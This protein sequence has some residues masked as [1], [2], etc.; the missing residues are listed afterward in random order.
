[1][2]YIHTK[3]LDDAFRPRLD[4]NP[5]Y[6]EGCFGDSSFAVYYSALEEDRCTK[7]I[8]YHLR[9]DEDLVE[10]PDPRYYQPMERSYSGS[11][12]M[13]SLL[14]KE[15]EHTDLTSSTSAG[16]PFCQ[17]LARDAVKR[18]YD[19]FLTA[20]ARNPEGT[21]VPV[22]TRT[23]LSEPQAGNEFLMTL[24]DGQAQFQAD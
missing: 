4:E 20:S 11:E 14:G 9:Q 18:G 17:S 13:V 21:C 5:P 23:A 3:V 24:Q 1:M 16:Y 15:H 10:C 7:E 12:M 8:A 2:P 6:P 19:G 22:F